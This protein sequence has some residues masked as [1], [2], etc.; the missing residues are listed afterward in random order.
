M[1][2]VRLDL[3]YDGTE[4]C[5]W[6]RQPGLRSVQQDLE[7]GLQRVLRSP[8]RLAVTVAGRTDAGVHAT[9]QVVHLDCP[10]ALWEQVAG[11]SGR[12]PHE[13]LVTR[14]GGVLA[15][16][17]V[18]RA[19]TPVSADF[20]ARFAATWRRYEYRISDSLHS[21]VPARRF[22]TLWHRHALDVAAMN[23]AAHF[24]LGLHDFAAFCRPREHSTTL[25]TLLDLSFERD[26][27]DGIIAARV[28]ADAFCH[29]MVRSLIGGL[30][31]VGEGRKSGAWFAETLESLDRSRATAVIAAR[32]LTLVEIAYPPED[33]WEAR[34]LVTRR[35]RDLEGGGHEVGG[36][37]SAR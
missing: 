14:L 34:G 8:S 25:R 1:Q 23:E 5:G 36:R 28:R 17:I 32:G 11:R 30:I 19:A 12:A 16:D 35:R 18:V 4:F 2:R 6:A 13:A 10:A 20:D 9:G 31:A 22:D 3:A 33:E 24:A 29:N 37:R 27:R 26:P 21:R 15:D 7:E